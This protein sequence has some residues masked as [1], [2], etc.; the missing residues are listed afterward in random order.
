M[1]ALV[2]AADGLQ[3]LVGADRLVWM[4]GD[5]SLSELSLCDSA[6]KCTVMSWPATSRSTRAASQIE[7]TSRRKRLVGRPDSDAVLP[8]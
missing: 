2:V 3:Q 7:P 8:A 1:V 5:G 6:A 4:N